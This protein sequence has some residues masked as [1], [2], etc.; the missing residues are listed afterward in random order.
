M[1][2]IKI[3]EIDTGYILENGN[4]HIEVSWADFNGIVKYCNDRDARNEIKEYLSDYDDESAEKSFDMASEKIIGDAELMDRVVARL[5]KIR[6]NN[7]T[8]DD[9]HEAIVSECG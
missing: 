5:I 8:T 7:E 3:T 6:I 2:Q 1:N 9:I 4:G